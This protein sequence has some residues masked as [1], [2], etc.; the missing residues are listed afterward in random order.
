MAKGPDWLLGFGFQVTDKKLL[1]YLGDVE[2]KFKSLSK[3]MKNFNKSSSSKSGLDMSGF[4]KTFKARGRGSLTEGMSGLSKSV[5][6]VV[7]R[8]DLGLQH[9]NKTGRDISLGLHRSIETLFEDI[10]KGA[11]K[12]AKN[13][14]A[15]PDILLQLP[16]ISKEAETSLSKLF[17]GL[18]SGKATH[19]DMV[20]TFKKLR[21]E[22]KK[23]VSDSSGFEEVTSRFDRAGREV[24]NLFNLLRPSTTDEIFKNAGEGLSMMFGAVADKAKKWHKERSAKKADKKAFDTKQ[25]ADFN[26]EV[27]T[28]IGRLNALDDIG[29]PARIK[30][31]RKVIFEYSKKLA[32]VSLKMGKMFVRVPLLTRLFGKKKDLVTQRMELG[33]ISKETEGLEKF[34]DSKRLPELSGLKLEEFLSAQQSNSA[35]IELE[36]EK[37]VDAYFKSIQD[38]ASKV[39]AAAVVVPAAKDVAARA[40]D[41][42]RVVAAA[43]SPEAIV[44][45]VEK[46]SPGKGITGP[47]SDLF[48]QSEK[49]LPNVFYAIERSVADLWATLKNGTAIEAAM[50]GITKLKDTISDLMVHGISPMKTSMEE[51]LLS[52]KAQIADFGEYFADWVTGAMSYNFDKFRERINRSARTFSNLKT[53]ADDAFSEILK[54]K[55]LFVQEFEANFEKLSNKVGGH[56]GQISLV[57]EEEFRKLESKLQASY[58]HMESLSRVGTEQQASAITRGFDKL[59]QGIKNT[60]RS[61][62]EN[63]LERSGALKKALGLN[64]F[65]VLGM[66]SKLAPALA[67]VGPAAARAGAAGAGGRAA[68]GGA[69]KGLGMKGALGDF[70]KQKIGDKA[71]EGLSS[72]ISDR[73]SQM[74][75]GGSEER[76]ERAPAIQAPPATDSSQAVVD[77]IRNMA[78][79]L[80]TQLNKVVAASAKKSPAPVAGQLKVNSDEMKRVF[81]ASLKNAGGLSGSAR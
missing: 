70:F 76:A 55:E 60:Q 34:A 5:E 23:V 22:I 63:L 72:S 53:K 1:K 50:S 64:P 10:D 58:S 81:S 59:D 3:N 31:I 26:A 45:K 36:G 18:Q 40:D 13:L 75:G 69:T 61:T 19:A 62:V 74:S 44:E 38:A 47:L 30:N 4:E 41:V 48:E 43:L 65:P 29:E 15:L 79:Q 56:V 77:A 68:A 71:R 6:D 17:D 11:F 78:S 39:D 35:Q 21:K 28:L 54:A 37:L 24:T 32:P 27:N 25:I 52:A 67:R 14:E 49:E 8:V 9:V 2:D 16:G 51:A 80:M 12:S 66:L 73:M 46:M 7:R 42:A 20:S 33:K 57:T